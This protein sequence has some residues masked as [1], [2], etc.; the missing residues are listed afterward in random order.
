M[1]R[2]QLQ[3]QC[4]QRC[5]RGKEPKAVSKT[6]IPTMAAAEAKRNS[7]KLTQG[8]G[9]RERAPV[10]GVAVSDIPPGILGPHSMDGIRE[11]AP[12]KGVKDSD[13]PAQPLDLVGTRE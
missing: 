8:N 10:R 7:R 6:R 9:K 2:G 1:T 3:D 11:R 12:G 5:F 13:N 4:S